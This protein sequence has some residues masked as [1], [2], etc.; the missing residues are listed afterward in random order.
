MRRDFRRVMRGYDPAEVDE[1]LE[2]VATWFSGKGLER[3]AEQHME[4]AEA[5]LT[6]QR[7]ALERER[8]EAKAET[9]QTAERVRGEL[10]AARVET[11]DA[12]EAARREAEG[13]VAS[14]R[15]E[16]AAAR[17]GARG[18]GG[19]WGRRP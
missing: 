19:H 17:E 4:A 12:R 14:A 16:A 1:H 9:E 7:E 11:V 18:G 6:H 3:V 2:T 15:E 10:E 13:V 8:T 5:A